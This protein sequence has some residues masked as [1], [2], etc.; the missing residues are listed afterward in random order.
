MRRT[1]LCGLNLLWCAAVIVGFVLNADAQF[2]ASVQGTVTDT[3]NAVVPGATVTLTNTETGQTQQT[4][5]SDE[6]FYRFSALPPGIYTIS[7]EQSSFKKRVIENVKVDA[8]AVRG[9][10]VQLETGGIAET[11]TVEAEDAALQTEDANVQKTITTQEVERLPQVG[12]DVYELIRLAPGVFGAGAR[13][14]S[15]ASVGL[16]NT[17]GP[18][19]SNEGIFQ[20]ENR[21]AVSANGQRVSANNFQ[22]DGVSVNSQTW[23]GAAV[24]TP[25]QEAVK[26]VQVT[27]S[28]YSAEDG[29]NSGAQI[30]VVS[31]NGTN[32]FR[33]SAFFKYND[34]GWNAFTPTINIAGTT[35][36]IQANRVET[37]NK[38]FGGSFGGPVLRNKLFFFFAYEGGRV[39]NTDTYEAFIETDQLRQF[40][41]SRGGVSAQIVGAA[42]SQ[43]RVVSILP[44][45]CANY[46]FSANGNRCRNVAGGLDLGSPLGALRQYVPTTAPV[47][48]GLNRTQQESFGGGFDGIPDIQ[49]A[50]LV[51]P[52]VQRGD[53]YVTRIDYEATKKDKL[54]STLR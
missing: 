43:P 51:D 17:S 45:E 33:G 31:Q 8:E 36:R 38:T 12:R 14:G 25:T 10:D 40:I 27:S 13:S 47:T 4:V 3:V 50:L 21:P 34:P 28:S 29:R 16:P 6:G 18:G 7:F 32:R 49:R 24:I 54:A 9:V 44:V 52:G 26:E 11:V 19:G 46:T 15:G 23:G 1:T 39:N 35:R 5:A 22:I 41:I 20:T 53:Q 30:R 48:G 37:R 2:R 42:G